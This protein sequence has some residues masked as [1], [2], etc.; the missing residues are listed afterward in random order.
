MP[1]ADLALLEAAAREAGELALARVGDHGAVREKP[2]LGPVS[3]VDLAVDRLLGQR[4]I[5]ARPGLRLALGGE[6][7]RP[8]APGGRLAA[9]R[10]FIVDPIDG[11]RAFLAGDK[12]WALSLAVVEGGRGRWRRSCTC[13]RS[14]APTPRR[15]GRGRG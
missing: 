6:R 14:G 1:E 10:V 12:A 2:G 7:G 11:T 5:A 8:R 9:R 15:R 3:E 4:L 13:R